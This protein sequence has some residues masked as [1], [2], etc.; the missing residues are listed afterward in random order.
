MKTTVVVEREVAEKVQKIERGEER[1]ESER[2]AINWLRSDNRKLRQCAK[3]KA[4]IL[5]RSSKGFAAGLSAPKKKKQKSKANGDTHS[6]TRTRTHHHRANQ[7]RKTQFKNRQWDAPRHQITQQ[8]PHAAPT[9]ASSKSSNTL[10]PLSL[11]SLS[12]SLSLE[13]I[14]F[15]HVHAL[16]PKRTHQS[17]HCWRAE[18]PL[19]NP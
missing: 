9:T 4:A 8:K 17:L 15:W 1:G 10:C 7:K 3:T 5:S 16:S 14:S 13:M 19:S 6:H 18:R 12:P 11:L 2:K